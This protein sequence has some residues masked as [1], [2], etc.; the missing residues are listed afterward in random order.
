MDEIFD[1]EEFTYYPNITFLSNISIK[2]ERDISL[3]I[4]DKY[5]LMNINIT[6]DALEESSLDSTISNVSKVVIKNNMK[7]NNISYSDFSS[8]SEMK[9]ILD[10]ENVSL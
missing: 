3:I 7:K 4:L 2:N 6:S 8:A 1:I 9:K 5:K 10:K